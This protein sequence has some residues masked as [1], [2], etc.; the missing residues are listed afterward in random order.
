MLSAPPPLDLA[1]DVNDEWT[2][3]QRLYR[4][5]SVGSW[6]VTSMGRGFDWE[7]EN[8]DRSDKAYGQRERERGGGEDRADTPRQRWASP[9]FIDRP[10]PADIA[11]LKTPITPHPAKIMRPVTNVTPI[12]AEPIMAS[13]LTAEPAGFYSPNMA[14]SVPP[15]PSLSRHPSSRS[16]G[17]PRPRRRS[18][19][20]RVS[21]I[22]GRVS[23]APSEPPS[24]Q[25]AAKSLNRMSSQS[26]LLSVASS[27]RAP[28]PARSESFLGEKTIAD[29][30]LDGDIGRGA[31]G[32][33]SRA[34]P[35]NDDGSLGVSLYLFAAVGWLA[36]PSC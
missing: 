25:L 32:V 22:A 8:D 23:I 11:A 6:G 9:S 28:S 12:V 36:C 7:D 21:L 13:T 26:S 24:P 34:R 35:V 27:T 30:K 2:P 29:F 3:Q 15:S 5:A 20:Q 31:Y 1:F 16:G 4:T 17:M 10:E 18:S 14:S 33:V 19:Q